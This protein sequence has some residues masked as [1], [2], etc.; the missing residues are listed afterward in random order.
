MFLCLAVL[1]GSAA[2]VWWIYQTEPEAQQINAKR[3]SAALVETIVVER[4][5][6]S[7]NLVVLGTVRPAQD[8]VL[9]PRIRGQ[10]LELSPSF[11]PGGMVGKGDLLMRIDPADFKN[12]VSI[13]KSELEQVEADW[14]IESGRQK[15]AKQEL[16]LLG[17]S[18]GKVNAALVLREPQSAS[19]QSKM[20][21]AKAAVERAILD[22][23][24]TEI[25]APFDAQILDRSVNVG[26][27]VEPGDELGQ[28]VGID[29]YWVM[30]AVPTRNLRWVRFSSDEQQGSEATLHNP[31][32]WGN[33]VHRQGRV[34]RMIGSLDQQ[35]R[36]ARVLVVVD[37]PL[38]LQ[39]DVPP[40]ILDSLLKL[41][42]AGK[43]IDNVVRL[44][45]EHVHNGDTVWVMKDGELEIRDTVIEFRDPEFAYISSGLETGDEVVTTTLATVANGVKLRKVD[46]PAVPEDSETDDAQSAEASE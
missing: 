12:I 24:R 17:D 10:V 39:S 8:I 36:L 41:Q 4:N 15:L 14:E 16:D 43:E 34:H 1:A 44:D 30:A 22:L 33:D 3:K 28:L 46:A 27:Q 26:S 31:D 18:I 23:D 7:P 37:D 2:G 38:G 25:V 35:T 11:A 45:R 42:I 19:L 32:A 29:Q 21:A 40:L 5:T 13:R 20:S 6:Y 9:S